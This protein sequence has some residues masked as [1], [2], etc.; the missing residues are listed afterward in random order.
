MRQCLV[1]IKGKF[2]AAAIMNHRGSLSQNRLEALQFSQSAPFGQRFFL[3]CEKF[4]IKK[5][6]A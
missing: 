5:L 3:L 4:S 2:A 6:R 1:G